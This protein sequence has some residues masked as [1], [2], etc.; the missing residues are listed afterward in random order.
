MQ[1]HEE[2]GA[3]RREID[4]PIDREAAWDLI[5]DPRE[6]ETW[7]AEEV[8]LEAIGEGAEGSITLR[9]GRVRQACIEE[10][11]PGRRVSLC[12]WSEDEDPTLVDLTLDDITGGTRLT[13]VEMPVQTLRAVGT[14]ITGGVRQVPGPQMAVPV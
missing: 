1:L 8:R 4:L 3:V 9:D 14:A 11:E 6:L 2:M 7:L 5:S 10:V 13:V 12:W